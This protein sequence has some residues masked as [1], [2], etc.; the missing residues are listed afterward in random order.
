MDRRF[1]PLISGGRNKMKTET[2]D[3]AGKFL[4]G[5]LTDAE[6]TEIEKRYF[7]D[8]KLFEEI[9]IAENELIDAYAAGKLSAEDQ[10]RFESRLLLNPKQ[11]QRVG[12]AKTFLEYA[13]KQSLAAENPNSSQVKSAWTAFISGLFSNKPVFSFAFAAAL[14]IIFGGG[15]WLILDRRAIQN[16][17]SGDLAVIHTPQQAQDE[18]IPNEIN[19][20]NQKIE[21][22]PEVLPPHDSIERK[23]TPPI[24]QETPQK[25]DAPRVF[26]LILSPGLTR[27]A[28]TSQRF[29]IPPKTDFVKMSLKFEETN[30]SSFQAILETVEGN[31]V[32]RSGKLK[33]RSG[34]SVDILIPAKNLKN[35]DFILSLKRL[36]DNGIYEPVADYSFTI[37]R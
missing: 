28:G 10:K 32:W 1:L 22:E 16:N 15:I 7:Q 25:E 30:L 14:L 35:A 34:N 21:S 24:K 3:I 37:S 26:S 20:S 18:K 6:Q 31:Q 17:Q 2:D 5:K 13:S 33:S 19:N 12:F 27:D 9:L 4:L 36:A 23:K 11:R 29:T 8:K